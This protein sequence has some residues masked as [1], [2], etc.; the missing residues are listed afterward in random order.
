MGEPDWTKENRFATVFGRKE[1][2]A[3]LDELI[4]DWTK[5]HTAEDVMT[6]MQA[7]GV[8]AGLV[9]NS[10]DLLGNPQFKERGMYQPLHHDEMGEVL[11]RGPAFQLSKTPWEL[12]MPGPC[13]GQH[14]EYVCREFLGMSDEELIPL[15]DSGAFE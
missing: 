3:A 11:H 8:S 6:L 7:A 2:E 1:N 13:L 10:A 5:D 15:L 4:G 9:E 14:T 12:M